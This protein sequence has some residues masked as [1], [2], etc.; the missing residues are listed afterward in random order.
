MMKVAITG[1]CGHLGISVMKEL[2]ARGIAYRALAFNDTEYLTRHQIDFVKGHVN[3]REDI[4]ALLKGCTDLIHCAGVISIDG[5]KDGLV[6]KV[7]IE[8]VDLVMSTALSL[9]LNKVVHISSIHAYQHEPRHEVMD[10]TGSYVKDTAAAYDKSKRDGELIVKEYARKGLNVVIL[11]PTSVTGPPDHRL[12]PQGKAILDIY[13]KKIPAIFEG[14]FDW[15]DVRDVASSIC[16]ALNMGEKGESYFLGGKYYTM[17]EIVSIISELKG[18][19][20]RIP[21]IPLW[22]ARSG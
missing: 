21:S 1:A 15:V 4:N 19:R 6:Q 20:I 7:N 8:G 5:D 22:M 10:E 3:N 14:G 12:S 17:R 16:N 9:N 11:N 2:D 13:K 18:E